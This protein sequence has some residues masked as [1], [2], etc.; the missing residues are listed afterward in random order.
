MLTDDAGPIATRYDHFES[1]YVEETP[2]P[3][4]SAAV[5]WW[6]IRASQQPAD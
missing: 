5:I 4:L 6:L 3:E 2:K 1:I